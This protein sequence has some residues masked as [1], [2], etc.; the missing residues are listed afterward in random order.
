MRSSTSNRSPPATRGS[1]A[2]ITRPMRCGRSGSSPSRRAC[3][4]ASRCP[5]GRVLRHAKLDRFGLTAPPIRGKMRPIFA[6]RR[7]WT[8]RP[9]RRRAIAAGRTSR[10]LRRSGMHHHGRKGVVPMGVSPRKILAIG[11]SLAG[12]STWPLRPRARP[13]RPMRASSRRRNGN[14]SPGT[15]TAPP[16]PSSARSTSTTSS[17][18]TTRSRRRTRTSARRSRSARAS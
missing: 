9:A 13:R 16:R 8:I 15:F 1:P 4:P 18:I 10:G 2:L 7:D 17:R 14:R 11:L 12:S 6:R 5:P 3:E